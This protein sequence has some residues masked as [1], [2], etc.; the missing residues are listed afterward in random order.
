MRAERA[1]GEPTDRDEPNWVLHEG[2]CLAAGGLA[3]LED[4]S[5][6]IVITV[7]VRLPTSYGEA[8]R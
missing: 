8:G 1:H 4:R 3:R 2:D 7:T 6:D 5:V